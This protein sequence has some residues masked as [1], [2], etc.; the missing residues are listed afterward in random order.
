MKVWV[1]FDPFVLNELRAYHILVCN[2]EYNNVFQL[3]N[4]SYL[5]DYSSVSDQYLPVYREFYSL[6]DGNTFTIPNPI[7][8]QMKVIEE[9]RINKMKIDK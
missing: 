4:L 9:K 2:I 8:F 3:L 5:N 7:F 1:K 6:S